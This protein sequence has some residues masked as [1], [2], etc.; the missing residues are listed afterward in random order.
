MHVRVQGTATTNRF[1]PSTPWR[2][3]TRCHSYRTHGNRPWV[4]VPMAAAVAMATTNHQQVCSQH[5]A[6]SPQPLPQSSGKRATKGPKWDTFLTNSSN[7]PPKGDFAVFLS[8]FGLLVASFS[9]FFQLLSTVSI[10]RVSLLIPSCHVKKKMNPTSCLW[11]LPSVRKE[12]KQVIDRL[13]SPPHPWPG[14][15]QTPT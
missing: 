15:P 1:V 7:A 3:H 13:D 8:H 4:S 5:T 12:G 11:S 10:G 14:S 6:T 9:P 2:H